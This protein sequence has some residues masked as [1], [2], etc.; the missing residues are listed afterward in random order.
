M[1]APVEL[2]GVSVLRTEFDGTPIALLARGPSMPTGGGS[3]AG[4][5]DARGFDAAESREILELPTCKPA[6]LAAQA[7]LAAEAAEAACEADE[8]RGQ[9]G[10]LAAQVD[11]L[12]DQLGDSYEELSLIYRLSSGMQLARPPQAFFDESCRDVRSIMQVGAVGLAFWDSQITPVPRSI[13]GEA[14]LD[15]PALDKLEFALRE[16]LGSGVQEPIIAN[17]LGLDRTLAWLSGQVQTLLAVPVVRQQRVVGA[18]WAINKNDTGSPTGQQFTSVDV[19]LLAGVANELAVYAENTAYYQDSQGLL[20]G[21]LHALTSAVDAKDAYTCGHSERVALVSRELAEKAGFG[22]H[23]CERIYMAGLLHDV[24]KIGIPDAVIR[25]AGKLTDEEFDEVKK[26]PEIG[27]RILA[28]ITQIEDLIPGVRH[29]HERFDG[30]GYPW[31]LAGEEIPLMGRVLCLADCFDAM[32]SNRTYRQGM[33]LETA[34]AEISKCAGT[35]F[36]PELAGH[37]VSIG[38]TRLAEMIE[39]HGNGLASADHFIRRRAA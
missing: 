10:A 7:T 16:R 1:D 39:R 30:N 14:K 4:W 19:K 33:P 35:Q 29:H 36:D 28:D 11:S 21:L 17:T 18:C 38:E 2:D 15:S 37:F 6:V 20:M 31:R 5:C 25:K 13:H 24:G 22:A 9:A 27:A 23:F 32:T 3:R 12:S 26:H 8:W 34:L